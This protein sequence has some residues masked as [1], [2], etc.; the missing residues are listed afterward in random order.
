MMKSWQTDTYLLGKQKGG[1]ACGYKNEHQQYRSSFTN[2]SVERMRKVWYEYLSFWWRTKADS[3]TDIAWDGGTSYQD[4]SIGKMHKVQERRCATPYSFENRDW[5]PYGIDSHAWEIQKL[6]VRRAKRRRC[7]RRSIPLKKEKPSS[8]VGRKTKA[9]RKG[10][11][12][13]VPLQ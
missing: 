3:S 2:E 12:G 1:C 7:W 6:K 10:W 4:N 8:C 9:Y 5:L 13:S 11:L